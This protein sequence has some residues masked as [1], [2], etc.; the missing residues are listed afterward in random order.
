M[1]T[2]AT[3]TSV[4]LARVTHYIS[5]ERDGV[6][7]PDGERAVG[8]LGGS[9]TRGVLRSEGRADGGIAS[10]AGR[11]LGAGKAVGFNGGTAGR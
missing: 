2:C 10:M 11:A 8:R 4:L 7:G 9:Q 5:S 1:Q 3:Q 6:S